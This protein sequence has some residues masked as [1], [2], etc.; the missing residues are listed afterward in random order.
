M[1]NDIHIGSLI[2]L[3]R[4]IHIQISKG[5]KVQSILFVECSVVLFIRDLRGPVEQ[6]VI[7]RMILVS[8]E[9][10]SFAINGGRRGSNNF[11]YTRIDTRFEQ[12]EGSGDINVQR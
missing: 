6:V 4:T 11:F 9:I 3:T 5:D 1:H 7:E 8:W 2:R 10:Q 12:I